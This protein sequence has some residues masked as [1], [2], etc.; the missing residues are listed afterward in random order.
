MKHQ[1]ERVFLDG[2]TAGQVKAFL[3]DALNEVDDYGTYLNAEF[4]MKETDVGDIEMS[5]TWES[6]R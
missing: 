3:Q 6:G 5:L 2:P 1:V 4:R